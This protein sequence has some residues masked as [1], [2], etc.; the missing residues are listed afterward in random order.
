MQFFGGLLAASSKTWP[1]ATIITLIA[2]AQIKIVSAANIGAMTQS[3]IL[4]CY[5]QAITVSLLDNEAALQ[6]CDHAYSTG[7][8]DCYQVVKLLTFI[9]DRDAIELC[10]CALTVDPANCFL[11]AQAQTFLTQRQCIAICT[12][13]V[14]YSLNSLCQPQPESYSPSRTEPHS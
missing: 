7:P 11:Q 13:Q 8:V 9:E 2:L 1:K 4:Q 6:L 10:K 3:Q 14:I 12:A 5:M